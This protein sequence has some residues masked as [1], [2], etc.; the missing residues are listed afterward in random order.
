PSGGEVAEEGSGGRDDL[1]VALAA[2]ERGV[3]AL[4][5]LGGDEGDGTSVEVAVVALA[6]PDVLV[7]RGPSVRKR[8]PGCLDGAVLVGRD[9][10]REA[11]AAS[12]LPE[13]AGLAT[14]HFRE[15]AGEPAGGDAGLVVG[16]GGVRLVHDLDCHQDSRTS[17][18]R[19]VWLIAFSS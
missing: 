17:T 15:P 10:G 18:G 11:V 14:A 3:D 1:A 19:R 6:Q 4:G 9:P 8:D 13:C 16:G 7:D 2:G 5:S 12:A